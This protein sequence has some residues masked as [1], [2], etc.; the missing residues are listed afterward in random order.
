MYYLDF[1]FPGVAMGSNVRVGR[2]IS[3][4][5]IEAQLAPN[6]LT[7]THSLLYTDDPFTQT[8]ILA[9]VKLSKN[10][11]IQAGVS[12]GSDVAPWVKSERHLTAVACVQWTSPGV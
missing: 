6:N 11:Q 7:Y 10:W 4:P 3:I 8:G 5:D 9:T 12:A 1:W 2:Y